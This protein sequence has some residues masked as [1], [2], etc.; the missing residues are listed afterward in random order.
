MIAAST[1]DTDMP[2]RKVGPVNCELLPRETGRTGCG[3]ACSS[4][5]SAVSRGIAESESGILRMRSIAVLKES[6]LKAI[7]RDR[8]RK[9]ENATYTSQAQPS[10]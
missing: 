7:N 2:V 1:A 10:Q 5:K 9:S 8:K 3:D 6:Q 4:R